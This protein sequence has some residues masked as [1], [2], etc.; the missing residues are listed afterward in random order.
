LNLLPPL[1]RLYLPKAH[2]DLML[3]MDEMF[4]QMEDG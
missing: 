1:I 4:A 3:P 2:R